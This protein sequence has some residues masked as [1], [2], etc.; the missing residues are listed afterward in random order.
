MYPVEAWADLKTGK[1]IKW[2]NKH[3]GL[4]EQSLAIA[5]V[6]DRVTTEDQAKEI[7]VM[8]KEMCQLS[9]EM[10]GLEQSLS[11]LREDVMGKMKQMMNTLNSMH[12]HKINE[13]NVHNEGAAIEKFSPDKVNEKRTV[14]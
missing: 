6:G 5:K 13:T 3:G 12:S 9:A 7:V 14:V 8:K 2:V 4:L 10:G 1:L 11:S